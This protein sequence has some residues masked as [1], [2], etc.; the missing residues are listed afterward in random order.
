[1]NPMLDPDLIE[2]MDDQTLL[3]AYAM[4]TGALD[5]DDIAAISA[6]LARRNL[7]PPPPMAGLPGR[8]DMR[9]AS[10]GA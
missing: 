5:R 10:L 8:F 7:M 3:A 9:P 1:M 2:Y 6:E 4:A